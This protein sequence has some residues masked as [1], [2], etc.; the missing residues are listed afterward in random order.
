MTQ[1]EAES[2]PAD[3]EQHCLLGDQAASAGFAARQLRWSSGTD[4]N[5]VGEQPHPAPTDVEAYP[6]HPE[7]VTDEDRI[8]RVPRQRTGGHDRE[9]VVVLPEP[10]GPDHAVTMGAPPTMGTPP[11][12]RTDRPGW[13][14]AHRHGAVRPRQ[15]INRRERPPRRWC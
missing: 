9:G 1:G 2:G 6:A 14:G 11:T 8:D 5:P 12:C 3:G 15:R 13:A 7:P 10:T 4:A